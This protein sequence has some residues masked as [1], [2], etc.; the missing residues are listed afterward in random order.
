MAKFLF[1]LDSGTPVF[2]GDVLWHPDR[3]RV[4][5]YCYAEFEPKELGSPFV[6]VRSDNGAV[7]EVYISELRKEPPPEPKRCSK[8]GQL[9]PDQESSN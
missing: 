7:P 2:Y 6:T 5:W 3:K 9:L 4:G 8:C 1:T